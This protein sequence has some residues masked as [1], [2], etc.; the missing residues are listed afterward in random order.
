MIDWLSHHAGM[1]GLLFFFTFFTL[2]VLWVFRPGAKESYRKKSH[3]P[4]NE[5]RHD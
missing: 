3:I 4:L 5:D 2:T 1:M